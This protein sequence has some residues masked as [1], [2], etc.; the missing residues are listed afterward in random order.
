MTIEGN[1]VGSSYS[2]NSRRRRTPLKPPKYPLSPPSR[3]TYSEVGRF[4]H[5]YEGNG[6]L[7]A[8]SQTAVSTDRSR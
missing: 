1:R 4:L 8:A 6:G 2:E 5:D 3:I 7:C